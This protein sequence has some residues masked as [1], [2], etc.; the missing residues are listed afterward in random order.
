EVVVDV[1]LLAG[2]PLRQQ[3]LGELH[4]GGSVGIDALA[5][6]RRLG[7]TALPEPEVTLAGEQAIAQQLPQDAIEVALAE[8]PLSRDEYVLYV[9][10]MIEHD[11]PPPT[12][13]QLDDVTVGSGARE[14]EAELIVA[15]AGDVAE[16]Q[17]APGSRRN[18]WRHASIL[19]APPRRCCLSRSVASADDGAHP[20]ELLLQGHRR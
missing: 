17:V 18:A 5:V 6:E 14:Q 3:F 12:E 2:A 13:T 20:A 10:W 9:V 8:A 7:Q 11:D 19:D 1:A 15:D 16:Q 4:H